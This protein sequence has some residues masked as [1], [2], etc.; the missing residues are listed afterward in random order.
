MYLFLDGISDQDQTLLI[1]GRSA[2]EAAIL[3]AN[4]WIDS[5]TNQFKV[6]KRSENG[7]ILGIRSVSQNDLDNESLDLTTGFTYIHEEGYDQT[8]L[9]TDD[10]YES[11]KKREY[12]KHVKDFKNKFKNNKI[13]VCSVPQY[14]KPKVYDPNQKGV[15]EFLAEEINTI[16][17]S[18]YDFS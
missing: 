14:I 3:Y 4:Y 13:I 5:F 9:I 11:I 10:S 18:D 2:D 16:N 17:I 12:D 15:I 6:T 8:V 1:T 7:Y